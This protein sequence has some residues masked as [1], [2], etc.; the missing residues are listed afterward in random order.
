MDIGRFCDIF[1]K[2]HIYMIGVLLYFC[3]TGEYYS[4]ESKNDTIYLKLSGHVKELLNAM[5]NPNID[6]IPS[7]EQILGFPALHPERLVGT[8]GV[9]TNYNL[10]QSQMSELKIM[11]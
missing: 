8:V 2:I 5:L 10:F 1:E 7:I 3:L 6:Q 11:V 9:Q 4:F